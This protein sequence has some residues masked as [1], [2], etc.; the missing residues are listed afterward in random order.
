MVWNYRIMKKGKEYVVIELFY[1]NKYKFYGY[2]EISITGESKNDIL[3]ILRNQNSIL[4]SEKRS[5]GFWELL[6]MKM[7]YDDVLKK[8]VLDEAFILDKC[9][10]SLW[11][12]YWNKSRW[13]SA[14]EF[15]EKYMV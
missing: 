3:K 4:T 2:A 1:K 10:R 13:V 5:D 12:T 15:L 6:D 11:R 14:K 9:S 8:K 7:V